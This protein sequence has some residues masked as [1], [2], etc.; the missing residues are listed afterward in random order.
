V[1]TYTD[2]HGLKELAREILGID[3][4]K[5]QQSSEYPKPISQC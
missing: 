2:R 3:L 1:R 5:Q 4:S